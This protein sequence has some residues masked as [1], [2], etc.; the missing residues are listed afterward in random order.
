M[1]YTKKI[2]IQSHSEDDLIK[3]GSVQVNYFTDSLTVKGFF[4]SKEDL[5]NVVNY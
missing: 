5:E 1:T 3:T 2:K 4:L